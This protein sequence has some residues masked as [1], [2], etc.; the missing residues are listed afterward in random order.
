MRRLVVRLKKAKWIDYVLVDGRN[1]DFHY[2]RKVR[3]YVGEVECQSSK[4]VVSLDEYNPLLR[5]NWWISNVFFFLITVFGIFDVHES[6]KRGKH[7]EL[8]AFLNE[9]G[10]VL[11]LN[12][13]RQ[14]PRIMEWKASFYIDE[15]KN[16]YC[17][18]PVISRRHALLTWTKALIIL[19]TI[20]ALIALF[21]N[22]INH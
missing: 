2:D 1:L 12:P 20:G 7:F 16:E 15:A 5:W 8:N 3:A 9:D 18:D 11:D 22:L 17:K 14:S 6:F 13:S 19:G 4:V 21:V 10:N